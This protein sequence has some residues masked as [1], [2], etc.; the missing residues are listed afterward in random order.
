MALWVHHSR[1]DFRP[2]I[3]NNVFIFTK[4]FDGK[5]REMNRLKM[6]WFSSPTK[7]KE[8]QLYQV[9]CLS[10]SLFLHFTYS[11]S[12]V[13]TR[14]NPVRSISFH[15]LTFFC[16]SQ[17]HFLQIYFLSLSLL[18]PPITQLTL[19]LSLCLLNQKH[20]LCSLTFSL[21]FSQIP[22]FLPLSYTLSFI[23]SLS[24]FLSFSLSHLISFFLSLS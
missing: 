9:N 14:P 19:F 17:V 15:F 23:L 24:F 6:F 4:N 8:S 2:K 13:F 16:S 10:L 1:R 5:I 22:T 3:G 12:H 7:W 18:H 11:Q 21:S 20:S